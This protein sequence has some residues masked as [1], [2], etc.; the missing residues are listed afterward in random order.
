MAAD[1][2]ERAVDL[3]ITQIERQFGK[4]SI[5]RLGGKEILAD[6]STVFLVPTSLAVYEVG[7][8]LLEL[9][10]YGQDDSEGI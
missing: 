10:R 2:R 1:D 4:G 8:F 9:N 7:K 3:A 5:M 6:G